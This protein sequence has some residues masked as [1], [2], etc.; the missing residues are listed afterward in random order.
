MSIF[1]RI[2]FPMKNVVRRRP[3]VRLAVEGLENRIVPTVKVGIN[4]ATHTLTLTGDGKNE[5]VVILETPGTTSINIDNNGDG[6]L[7]QFLDTF[8]FNGGIRSFEHFKFDLGGGNDRI[9]F[10]AMHNLDTLR[11]FQVTDTKGDNS[12]TFDSQ[13]FAIGGGLNLSYQGGNGSDS[14]TTLFDAISSSSVTLNLNQAGGN[15]QFSLLHR[16]A[17]TNSAVTITQSG[18]DGAD[19]ANIFYQPASAFVHSTASVT[20]DGAEGNDGFNVSINSARI[21][22]GSALSYNATMGNGKDVLNYRVNSPVADIGSTGSVTLH[23]S[24]G[25]GDDTF[26]STLGYDAG[27]I[28]AGSTVITQVD[29]GKGNDLFFVAPVTFFGNDLVLQGDVEYEL[30]GGAGKDSIT[31]AT[32]DILGGSNHAMILGDTATFRVRIDGGDD[33]DTITAVLNLFA[34]DPGNTNRSTIYVKA[35]AGNDTVKLTGVGSPLSNP[36]LA[37]IVL[38]GGLGSDTYSEVLLGPFPRTSLGF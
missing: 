12:F 32:L 38:D 10:R 1:D 29:G 9:E 34:T 16:G 11:D 4:A 26:T 2:G 14:I 28:A 35:G 8:V 20:F 25:D 3:S 31:F 22:D 18:G 7:D 27:F 24:L 36:L 33:A 15:D 19:A 21:T 37:S 13:G 5:Q 30:S 23:G 17:I 6:A